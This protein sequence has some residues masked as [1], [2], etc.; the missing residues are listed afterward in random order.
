MAKKKE[1]KKATVKTNTDLEKE[2]DRVRKIFT[3]KLISKFDLTLGTT[4]TGCLQIRRGGEVIM[5]G[6]RNYFKICLPKETIKA[7]GV[8][9]RSC[10]SNHHMS[11]VEY[12]DVTPEAIMLRLKDKRTNAEIE[13]EVYDGGISEARERYFSLQKEADKTSQKKAKA[14]GT[15]KKAASAKRKGKS[16]TTAA[17]ARAT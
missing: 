4:K 16:K 15:K 8:H 13:K 5:A 11:W 6:T 14:K 17:S 9:A 7:I 10:E 2:K 1:M 12:E 3:D